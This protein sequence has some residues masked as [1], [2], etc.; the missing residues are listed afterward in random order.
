MVKMTVV[1]DSPIDHPPPPRLPTAARS[2][3][4]CHRWSPAIDK[5]TATLSTTVSSI[6]RMIWLLLKPHPMMLIFP[7]H[8]GL[9]QIQLLLNWMVLLF[10]PQIST[11]PRP[12]PSL[13]ATTLACWV[14]PPKV[15]FVW[16]TTTTT[17]KRA[18]AKRMTTIIILGTQFS[19]RQQW[20]KSATAQPWFLQRQR[21]PRWALTQITTRSRGFEKSSKLSS[22]KKMLTKIATGNW[23]GN[24]GGHFGYRPI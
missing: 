13:R 20:S 18:K 24:D 2:W 8:F 4:S 11:T 7:L 6:R 14:A 1:V 17:L 3:P 12:S 9:Q 23:D 21:Q 19:P 15:T 5:R 22:L 16:P 10:R